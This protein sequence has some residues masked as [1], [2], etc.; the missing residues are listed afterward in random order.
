MKLLTNTSIADGVVIVTASVHEIRPAE[1]LLIS[2]YGEPEVDFGG[3]F[4]GAGNS[5]PD[6]VELEFELPGRLRKIPSGLP[7]TQAFPLDQYLDAP[8]HAKLW[9][10]L[11]VGRLT[12]AMVTLNANSLISRGDEI[13]TIS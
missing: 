7:L 1:T 4:S 9:V 12:N 8:A 5:D 10:E 11:I 2:Q 13:F 6:L 3:S